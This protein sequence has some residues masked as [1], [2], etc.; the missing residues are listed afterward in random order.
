MIE[1][2]KTTRW[3][4]TNINN[5]VTECHTNFRL[6]VGPVRKVQQVI[7]FVTQRLKV[8]SQVQNIVI[9]LRYRHRHHQQNI[10]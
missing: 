7:S 8:R 2:S 9:R 5:V 1:K 4:T 6:G 3:H 10:M